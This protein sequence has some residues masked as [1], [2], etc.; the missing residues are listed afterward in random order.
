SWLRKGLLA[1]SMENC[2]FDWRDDLVA[3]AELFCAAEEAGLEPQIEFQ[4]VAAL[5]SARSGL[6][7]SGTSARAILANLSTYAVLEEARRNRRRKD[8][9]KSRTLRKSVPIR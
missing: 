3:L 5:S 7:G 9:K 1:F 4:A 2:R 6:G 8:S